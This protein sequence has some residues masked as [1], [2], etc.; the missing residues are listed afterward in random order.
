MGILR[1]LV[2]AAEADKALVDFLQFGIGPGEFGFVGEILGDGIGAEIDAARVHLALLEEEQVAG[3]GADVQQHGAVLKVAIIITEGVAKSG[4]GNV[5]QLEAQTGG[6]GDAEEAL[7][8]VGL[9][10]DEQDFKFAG[11]RGTK[12]LIIPDDFGE[13][14]T[15]RFA[16]PRTG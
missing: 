4:G 11:G 10:G 13:R 5:R 7:N 1:L 2:G 15:E 12:D 16:G 6:L 3:F 9:D 8:D 14:E